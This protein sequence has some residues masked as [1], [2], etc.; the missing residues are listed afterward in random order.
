MNSLSVFV[1]NRK[2]PIIATS[3][4]DM[5]NIAICPPKLS[6]SMSFN[7]NGI[8]RDN[9]AVAIPVNVTLRKKLMPGNC[10]IL[11]RYAIRN[12]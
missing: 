1:S 3:I 7:M 11:S 6:G 4:N 2:N 8:G 12:R 5:V 9:K 10:I